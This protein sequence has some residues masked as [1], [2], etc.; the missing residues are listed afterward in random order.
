MLAKDVSADLLLIY[1]DHILLCMVKENVLLFLISIENT[2][3]Y[4]EIS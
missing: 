2:N 1:G 4:Q 3:C